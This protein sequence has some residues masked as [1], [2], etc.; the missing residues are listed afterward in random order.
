MIYYMWRDLYGN[1][2]PFKVTSFKDKALDIQIP[3]AEVF[4][5]C[6]MFPTQGQYHT[7]KEF[8]YLCM[9]VPHQRELQRH[10]L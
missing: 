2:T 8:V 1:P 4:L 7:Q 3:L 5:G 6:K 10:F 9:C